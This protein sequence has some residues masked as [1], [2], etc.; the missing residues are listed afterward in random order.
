MEITRLR[1]QLTLIGEDPT[2]DTMPSSTATAAQID[3]NS[4]QQPDTVNQYISQFQQEKASIASF[5]MPPTPPPE[6]TP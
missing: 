2:Q 6:M 3:A 4:T 1:S 5:G